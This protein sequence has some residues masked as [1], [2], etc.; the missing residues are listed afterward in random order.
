VLEVGRGTIRRCGL[1]GLGVA[2][3]EE[4][5]NV[6]MDF[7]ENMLL[8]PWGCQSFLVCLWNKMYNSQ[9]LQCHACLDAGRFSDL[10]IVDWTSEPVSYPGI[11]NPI[12]GTTLWTNQYPRALDSSC[13]CIRRWPSRP[14]LERKAHWL[15]V[16]Y[17]SWLVLFIAMDILAMTTT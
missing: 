4:V 14:S 16:L 9:L 7:W 6:G 15:N 8:A 5:F 17:K 2:S 12:G 1:V 3:L 11:C 10:M 13:T